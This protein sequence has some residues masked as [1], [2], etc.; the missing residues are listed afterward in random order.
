MSIYDQRATRMWAAFASRPN[1]RPYDAITPTVV[2]FG[3]PGY[4]VNSASA[5]FARASQQMDWSRPDAID[6]ATLNVAVWK[7]IRGRGSRMPAPRHTLL[8]SPL[9]RSSD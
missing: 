3:A 6:E 2:P 1:T 5:P 8:V 4:P 7:S 9:G